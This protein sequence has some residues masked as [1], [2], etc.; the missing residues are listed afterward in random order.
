MVDVHAQ[1]DFEVCGWK[2]SVRS[3]ALAPCHGPPCLTQLSS[4]AFCSPPKGVKFLCAKK[5]RETEREIPVWEISMDEICLRK[6]GSAVL[7]AWAGGKPS[8]VCSC[9]CWRCLP[10]P[11]KLQWKPR[12]LG[13]NCWQGRRQLP[14][15]CGRRQSLPGSRP[16]QRH[17]LGS[18]FSNKY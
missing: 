3:S 7:H 15:C 2:G 14:A 1:A 13:F 5:T 4:Q 9:Y 16:K 6:P 17:E 10:G 11:G 8:D 12:D 18:P